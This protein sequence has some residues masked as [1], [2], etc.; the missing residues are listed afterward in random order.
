MCRAISLKKQAFVCQPDFSDWP[1]QPN[2]GQLG[3]YLGFNADKSE[4]A[5]T[6]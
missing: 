5:P 2:S 4:Q 3:H 6:L 1:K